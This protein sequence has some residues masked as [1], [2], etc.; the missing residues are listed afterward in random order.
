MADWLMG[1]DVEGRVFKTARNRYERNMRTLVSVAFGSLTLRE[2]GAA[3]CGQ[4][5]KQLAKLSYGRAKR[6]R[7]VLR[8]A[9]ELAVRYEV[10]PRNPSDYVGRLHREPH[11]PDALTAPEVNMIRPAIA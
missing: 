6:A 5:I 4:F 1:I 7:V 10:L 9:S 8:L 2:I 3:R 11:I